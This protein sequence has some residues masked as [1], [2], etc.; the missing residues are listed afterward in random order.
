[1]MAFDAWAGL[2]LPLGCLVLLI[3]AAV[4]APGLRHAR[5]SREGGTMFLSEAVMHWGYAWIDRLAH[6]A[7]KLGLSA[8]AVS[9]LSLF[10]GLTSG[11]SM[12]GGYY[13]VAAWLLTLS[14]LGD[15]MDGA[16]ARCWTPPWIATWSSFL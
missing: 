12:A 9:W 15:G 13:G 1:M 10:L 11:L 14:G 3:I 5:V 2:A 4:Q 7:L 16:M 8:T 6:L